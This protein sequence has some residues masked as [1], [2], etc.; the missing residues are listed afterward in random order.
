MSRCEDVA[1]SCSENALVRKQ[2]R[3]GIERGLGVKGIGV[4]VSDRDALM[5]ENVSVNIWRNFDRIYRRGYFQTLCLRTKSICEK[6]VMFAYFLLLIK[7]V[8]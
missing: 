5:F 7:A 1:K 8:L 2:Y 3:R 6:R 4:C